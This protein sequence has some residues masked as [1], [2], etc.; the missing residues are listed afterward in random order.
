MVFIGGPRQCGKTTLANS[1][2]K[3]FPYEKN[4]KGT[5]FDW[6]FDEDRKKILNRL[7]GREDELTIIGASIP[8]RF[9]SCQMGFLLQ[10]L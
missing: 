3:N 7:W 1:I 5:Y 6:D 10:K 2:L 4:R 8:L 9:R